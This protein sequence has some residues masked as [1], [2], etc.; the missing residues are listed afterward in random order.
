MTGSQMPLSNHAQMGM[1]APDR[2]GVSLICQVELKFQHYS[3][4]VPTIGHGYQSGQ[5]CTADRGAGNLPLDVC[6]IN[7]IYFVRNTD[8]AGHS[9]S[10]VNA[11][12][13]VS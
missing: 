3:V 13:G 10:G 11:I 4:T 12:Q 5:V 2:G 1:V 8:K 6:N 9:P 7:D